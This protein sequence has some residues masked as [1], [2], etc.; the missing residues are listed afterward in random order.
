[1]RTTITIDDDIAARL[2]RLAEDQK[3]NKKDIINEILRRGLEEARENPSIKKY[4]TRGKDL[5]QCRYPSMDDI[6]DIIAVA[7]GE[8]HK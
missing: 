8:S 4:T 1:M 3:K 6:S 5:G 7:E 2:L